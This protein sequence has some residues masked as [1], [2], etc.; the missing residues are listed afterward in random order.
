MLK[1][2]NFLNILMYISFFIIITRIYYLQVVKLDYYQEKLLKLTEK[3]V[4]G[5]ELPRGRIYDTSGNIIVDNRL[6]P[7]IYFK[8]N[9][10][11][12]NK[13]LISL[14]YKI[15]DHIEL[16]YSKLTNSYLKDFYLL[17]HDNIIKKRVNKLDLA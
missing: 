3:E 4:K 5:D 7:V 6:V 16:D 8:N 2:I 15:K 13:E 12:T 1:K 14:A 9:N 10:N 17:E 11:L